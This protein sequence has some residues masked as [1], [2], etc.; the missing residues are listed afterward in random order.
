MYLSNSLCYR[1]DAVQGELVLKQSTAGVEFRV[2]LLLDWLPN[3]G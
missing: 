2:F 3:Q 1:H